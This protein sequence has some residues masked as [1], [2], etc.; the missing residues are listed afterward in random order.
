MIKTTSAL[1][2]TAAICFL[3]FAPAYANQSVCDCSGKEGCVCADGSKISGAE[4]AT[5]NPALTAVLMFGMS[6][7]ALVF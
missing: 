6:L 5:F 1:L 7:A 4:G 2:F 3:L